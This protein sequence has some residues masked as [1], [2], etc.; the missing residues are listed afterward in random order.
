[1]SFHRKKTEVKQWKD[2]LDRN[3]EPLIAQCGAPSEIVLDSRRWRLFEQ[4]GV[5]WDSGWS[6]EQLS[7]GQARQLLD[8]LIREL[9]AE[10]VFWMDLVTML[11]RRFRA[12]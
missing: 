11:R 2:W 6:C 9:G 3:Q 7:D 12:Q 4:E 8:L 5:D 10:N 1:M